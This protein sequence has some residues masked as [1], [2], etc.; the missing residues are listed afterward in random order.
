MADVLI[1]VAIAV[2]VIA[3]WMLAGRF[4]TTRPGPGPDAGP[5]PTDTMRG[6]F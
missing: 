2:A 5:P 1:W 4:S 6:G 3:I